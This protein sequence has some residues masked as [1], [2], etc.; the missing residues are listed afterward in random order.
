[1]INHPAIV[2]ILV[3]A[4]FYALIGLGILC[5]RLLFTKDQDE[6]PVRFYG[7]SKQRKVKGPKDITPVEHDPYTEIIDH[8]PTYNR[9]DGVK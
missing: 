9:Q 4:I 6:Y 2:A 1:M 8:Y 5:Y 3:T 7:K